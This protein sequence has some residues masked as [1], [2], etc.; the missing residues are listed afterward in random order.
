M[1]CGFFRGQVRSPFSDCN[2]VR[3]VKCFTD[4]QLGSQIES[5]PS[6]LRP[7]EKRGDLEKTFSLSAGRRQGTS[8]W[9][10]DGARK[11]ITS[12][13]NKIHQHALIDGPGLGLILSAL[14]CRHLPIF[15]VSGLPSFR[16]GAGNRWAPSCGGESNPRVL[17]LHAELRGRLKAQHVC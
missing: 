15:R 8:E 6:P 12:A 13:R 16:L 10:R 14:R 9:I 17:H 5:A 7:R 2:S 11:T 3:T 1:R 4:R